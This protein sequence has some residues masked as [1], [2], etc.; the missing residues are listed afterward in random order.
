MVRTLLHTV[1]MIHNLYPS[2]HD[3]D[4]LKCSYICISDATLPLLSAPAFLVVV[5]SSVSG[6]G[7][8]TARPPLRSRRMLGRSF[9]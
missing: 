3:Y 7:I 2:I 9:G 1:R 6:N 8:D 4:T 5:P